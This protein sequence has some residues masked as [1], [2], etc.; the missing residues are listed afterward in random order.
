M[1]ATTRCILGCVS[2][3]HTGARSRYRKILIRRLF[4]S[5]RLGLL[6][7]IPDVTDDKHPKDAKSIPNATIQDIHN[8]LDEELSLFR[9]ERVACCRST[10]AQ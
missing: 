2:R 6:S 4:N 5:S 10:F 1:S 3:C 8:F 7:F 9:R